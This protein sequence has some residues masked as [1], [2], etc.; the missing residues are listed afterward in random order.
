MMNDYI[1]AAINNIDMHIAA[2]VK[3]LTAARGTMPNAAGLND[4]IE[5]RNNIVA[6]KKP[7]KA[8]V[9]PRRPTP[10]KRATV[11]KKRGS[12]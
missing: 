9:A 2:Q 5:A 10:A 6:M 12:I 4:L 7:A 11:A 8:S 3:T 1:D